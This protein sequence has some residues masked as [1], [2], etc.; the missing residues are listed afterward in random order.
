MYLWNLN[1][2]FQI[3]KR[4]HLRILCSLCINFHCCGNIPVPHDFLNHF[5]ICLVLA[6]SC[7]E[8][9]TQIMT[10]KWRQ[11]NCAAALFFC[12]LQFFLIVRQWNPLYSAV[13]CLRIMRTAKTVQ[14]NKVC[15][16]VYIRLTGKSRFLW[17]DFSSSN[18]CRTS[19]SIGISL[20]P[21]FVFG[22]VTEK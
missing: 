11:Q 21:A 5:Y 7:T 10:A 14:K 12:Q 13:Y 16:S 4:F 6:I 19:V 3:F 8:R 17:Y 2:S 18:A 22:V 20:V 1:L 15:I 9:M